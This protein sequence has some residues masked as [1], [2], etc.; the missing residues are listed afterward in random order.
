MFSE[1]AASADGKITFS[2]SDVIAARPFQAT[3]GSGILKG[4]HP[5][6]DAS[7]V[8]RMKDA[9]GSLIGKTN[10]DEF[11]FG[12]FSVTGTGIPRNPFAADRSCGGSSGGAACAASVIDGHVALGTSAG[13][14][15]TS[16]AAFCGVFGLTP[17]YGRVSR[18]G[19]IESVSSMGP[20]GI[21]ASKSGVLKK[22]LPAISGKDDNDPVTAAQPELRSGKREL[23]SVAIPRNITDNVSKAVRE[24]FDASA[25]TLRGMSV[26]VEYVDMPLLKYSMPAH[27]V[28]CAIEAAANLAGYCGMRCGRR[29]GDL[30]MPFN[31]YFVSFRSEYF[32]AETKLR[33]IM[34]TYMTMGENRRKMYLRA[35]GVRQLAINEYKEVLKRYDAVLTPSM[36]FVAPRFEEIEDMSSSASYM[37]GRF[38]VPPV[39]CGLPCVS[40]PCGYSDGLP[41]G[42]QFVSDHWEEDVL[43]HAAGSWEKNFSVK[44]PEALR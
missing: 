27:Y 41:I 5:V 34:G 14:S 39:F 42:M 10:M 17:T 33:T 24:A 21:L 25:D 18:H 30:S 20:I 19:Q 3:A 6:F 8:L 13:G 32:G 37:A 38:A 4:Y 12:M 23:R 11:G 15:I 2:V 29:D 26:D 7:A 22:Y 16:P 31:D 36:P 35:L 9:G 44:V 40:V 43:L 1:A 28:L